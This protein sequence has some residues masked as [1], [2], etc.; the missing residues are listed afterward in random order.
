MYADDLK[1]YRTI[2]D[3]NNTLMLQNNLNTLVA[4]SEDW[5]LKLIFIY[6]MYDYASLTQY[7][8]SVFGWQ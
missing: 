1:I 8:T 4:W 2:Y 3:I 5:L 7:K 6:Q